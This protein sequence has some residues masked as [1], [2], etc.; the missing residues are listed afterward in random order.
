[1]EHAIA[2]LSGTARA[3][4]RVWVDIG[5][6]FKTLAKWDVLHNDSLIVV[7]IDPL[8][9]N[10]QH[11]WQPETPRFVR[12]HGAC[13]EGPPGETTLYVHRSPTCGSLLPTRTNGPKLGVGRDACTGDE[14]TP[15]RVPSFP[16][17]QLLRRVRSPTRRIELLKIDVQGSELSCLRSAGAELRRVDN[18]LLEVQD[19][20]E[21]SGLL[22]YE[23][24]PS[25]TQLDELLASHHLRRQY[26]EWNAWAKNVREINCLYS[27]SHAAATR[28][29]ATGNFQH[30]G[31]MVSYDELPTS[32]VRPPQYLTQLKTSS[33][34]GERVDHRRGAGVRPL[35]HAAEEHGH[36]ESSP[37]RR[38][39]TRSRRR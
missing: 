21:A 28:L 27:S 35:H 6:S 3:A 26:C 7:G 34:A 11:P 20:E 4:P 39:G 29:W 23:S 13:A 8:K 24:S 9:A 1:M 5:T 32:F 25:L 37:R 12:V 14:P 38:T 2:A 31:S 10:I 22:T 18:V 19:A 16:L 30:S 15:T 17:H 33:F 36:G